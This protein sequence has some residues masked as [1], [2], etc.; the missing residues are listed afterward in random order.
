MKSVVAEAS[1]I[2]KAIEKALNDAK[3]PQE[4]SVKILETPLKNFLGFT[5][6]SAKIALMFTEPKAKKSS[7]KAQ[8]P[9]IKPK[10]AY[11]PKQEIPKSKN[12][13]SKPIE[14]AIKKERAKP[15]VWSNPMVKKVTHW[16]KDT[17]KAIDK[18]NKFTVEPNGYYLKIKFENP[19]YAEEHRQKQLFASLATLILSMLKREYK[20]PLRGYKII[21]TSNKD[22]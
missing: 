11:K 13:V 4:F 7:P 22:A 12:S 16:V 18:D 21:L 10:E 19:V 2:S 9:K 15:Q 3:N 14:T 17:L 5:I 1:S 20:R 8:P 6:R